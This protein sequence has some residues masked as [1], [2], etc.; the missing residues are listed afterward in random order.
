MRHLVLAGMAH[1]QYRLSPFYI[2]ATFRVS[3]NSMNNCGLNPADKQYRPWAHLALADMQSR[4]N[5]SYRD[6]ILGVSPKSV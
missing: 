2:D 4:P 3:L 1:I 5:T 6:G